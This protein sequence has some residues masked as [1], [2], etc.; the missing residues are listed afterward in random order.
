MRIVVI[1]IVV[2]PWSTGKHLRRALP[3]SALPTIALQRKLTARAEFGSIHQKNRDALAREYPLNTAR[4][5]KQQITIFDEA[6]RAFPIHQAQCGGH[7]GPM[8]SRFVHF[9]VCP[10]LIGIRGQGAE[11]AI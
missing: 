10:R 3:R 7:N 5:A 1:S 6:P 9:T 11:L 2:S 4:T 8:M